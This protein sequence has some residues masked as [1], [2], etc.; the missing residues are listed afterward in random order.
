MFHF[1]RNLRT[2]GDFNHYEPPLEIVHGL[3]F[4][5]VAL[6]FYANQDL[7][8]RVLFEEWQKLTYDTETYDIGYYQDYIGSISVFVLDRQDK[9]RYGVRLEE[10]YPNQLT[11]FHCLTVLVTQ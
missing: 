1:R 3:T 4:G 9:R 6:S 5:E 10:A 2:Q 7:D 8:E 11:P